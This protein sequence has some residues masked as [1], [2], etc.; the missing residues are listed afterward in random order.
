MKGKLYLDIETSP[1]I[2]LAWRTGYK[3]NISH[4]SIIKERE[5]ICIAWKWEGEDTVYG[6]NWEYDSKSRDKNLLKDFSK[7]YSQASEI[8]AQNGKAFDLKWIRTRIIINDLPPLP[9]VKVYDTLTSNRQHFN[10]NSNQLDYVDR[11]LGG[12]GKMETRYQMWKDVMNGDKKQLNYMLTYCM[13]DVERLEYVEKKTRKHIPQKTNSKKMLA[14]GNKCP[15]CN[16]KLHKHGF[17]YTGLASYRRYRCHDCGIN[18]YSTN[19][20]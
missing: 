14:K 8:V 15:D 16:S 11:V 4:E 19:M 18:V 1:D 13:D 2:V 9:H 10:F 20:V 17:Y 3:L 6:Q 5:I 7:V 12:K